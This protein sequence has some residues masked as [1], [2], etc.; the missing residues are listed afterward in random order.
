MSRGRGEGEDGPD[1][2]V[3][4]VMEDWEALT[5]GRVGVGES[6]R[7]ALTWKRM[8]GAGK[9]KRGFSLLDQYLLSTKTENAVK[10]YGHLSRRSSFVPIIRGE[11]SS[12][13]LKFYSVFIFRLQLYWDRGGIRGEGR[14]R[15][16]LRCNGSTNLSILPCYSI[17]G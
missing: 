12:F 13:H 4:R 16:F 2:H 17:G 15:G 11:Q 7:S 3:T 8:W 6:D 10:A 9:P 5:L 1:L 14:M